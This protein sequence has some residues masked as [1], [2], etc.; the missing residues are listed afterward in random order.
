[1]DNELN[2]NQ[3]WWGN[4]RAGSLAVRPK[5]RGHDTLEGSHFLPAPS[6][7]LSIAREPGREPHPGG[8]RRCNDHVLRF[9]PGSHVETA[10]VPSLCPHQDLFGAL[11]TQIWAHQTPQQ[12]LVSLETQKVCENTRRRCVVM[13]IFT[14]KHNFHHMI[15]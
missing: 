8:G 15:E 13:K 1:M 14:P 3:R 7:A 6:R 11:F 2:I 5:G 10:S 4:G 9:P 12:L